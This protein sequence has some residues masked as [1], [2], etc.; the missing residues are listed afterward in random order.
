MYV[1][2]YVTNNIFYSFASFVCN[3]YWNMHI[4][5]PGNV[6]VRVWKSTWAG[7]ESICVLTFSLT[8][9]FVPLFQVSPS[10]A[11]FSRWWSR[12]RS[13]PPIS[14]SHY[15]FD[16]WVHKKKRKEKRSVIIN[17]EHLFFLSTLR[18]IAEVVDRCFYE[19]LSNHYACPIK[20]SFISALTQFAWLNDFK[21]RKNHH[22]VMI[23]YKIISNN[24]IQLIY[25]M[26]L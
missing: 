26:D 17:F 16:E 24:G 3:A 19:I 6:C 11:Y 9:I 15:G 12:V 7:G 10:H 4:Y 21:L 18:K 25:T 23:S 22:R 13:S 8:I 1:H 14:A 5:V 2:R 20:Y